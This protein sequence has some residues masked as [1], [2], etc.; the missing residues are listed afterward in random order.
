[1]ISAM[2]SDAPRGILVRHRTSCTAGHT[3][4]VDLDQLIDDGWTLAVLAP[5]SWRRAVPLQHVP[6]LSLCGRRLSRARLERDGSL[7]GGGADEYEGWHPHAD[8]GSQEDHG[9]VSREEA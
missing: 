7:A 1:M 8:R 2:G 6:S 9:P 5:G 3:V 4:R